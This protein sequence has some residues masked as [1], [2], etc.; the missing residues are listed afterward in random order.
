MRYDAE[1]VLR[2][3][4][5]KGTGRNIMASTCITV[6]KLPPILRETDNII[7]FDWK[8]L[9]YNSANTIQAKEYIEAMFGRTGRGLDKPS[10]LCHGEHELPLPFRNRLVN[11]D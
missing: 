7:I 4:T 8:K 1:E 2:F 11:L 9:F 10:I 3:L 5:T 6:E